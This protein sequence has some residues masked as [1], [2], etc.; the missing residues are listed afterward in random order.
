MPTRFEG[1]LAVLYAGALHHL[2][3][4]MH[5]PGASH[6]DRERA[7]GALLRLHRA[8][9]ATGIK[10][11]A[12]RAAEL[13]AL[14]ST[15]RNLAGGAD[16]SIA[17]LE[18]EGLRDTAEE[19]RRMLVRAAREAFPED[20]AQA[21]RDDDPDVVADDSAVPP[22]DRSGSSNP[23]SEPPVGRVAPDRRDEYEALF[24]TCVV[25]PDK[26][27]KVNWYAKKMSEHQ[28]RYDEV[29]GAL[30]IPWWFIGAIHGL[31]SG[32]AFDR[33]LHNGDPLGARTKRVPPGRP[34]DGEPPFTWE[35]SARDALRYMKLDQWGDWSVSGTLYQ[36]EAYNGF[37]YRKYKINSPYLWSFSNHYE[38]GKYIRDHVFD[39]EATSNQCGAATL[40]RS[41]VN[42]GA[43][44]L[45]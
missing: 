16:E 28:R 19:A 42:S 26:V 45:R 34:T 27:D 9:S 21:P 20:A 4:L 31:E 25:R 23:S 11:L 38:S 2:T 17:P 6:A 36:W 24:D 41:L 30:D 13:N 14:A 43:V 22:H 37:G 3:V 12:Q 32:F 7:R 10:N 1:D 8:Y 29:G 15:L 18:L 33:H 35:T 40:L 39:T 5:A 44:R